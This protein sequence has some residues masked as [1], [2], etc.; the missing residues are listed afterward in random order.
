MWQLKVILIVYQISKSACR[1]GGGGG[2]KNTVCLLLVSSIHL[3]ISVFQKSAFY[4]HMIF[5]STE[6]PPTC[7]CY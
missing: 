7:K 1:K 6:V 5:A 4:F 2:A 3:I